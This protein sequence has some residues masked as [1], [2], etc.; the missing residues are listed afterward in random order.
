MPTRLL[1]MATV[2][3]FAPGLLR[4]EMVPGDS[5]G[6]DPTKQKLCEERS[7]ARFP[8]YTVVPFEIDKNYVARSRGVVPGFQGHSDTTFV[9]IENSILGTTMLMECSVSIGTGQYGPQAFYQEGGTPWHPIKPPQ[10]DPSISS[11]RGNEIAADRCREA[12]RIR[13]NR[14][15]FNHS[16]VLGSAV[17]VRAMRGVRY[18]V[19]GLIAGAKAERYD[20]V[21]TGTALYGSAGPDMLAI[22]FTCLFS[23]MLEVKAIQ[24]K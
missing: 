17:E 2:V 1:A 8:G 19:G 23:P 6:N 7:K 20:V 16:S 5:I 18:P 3:V 15:N 9:A 14:P 22:K 10:F 13:I 4:G 21:V 12:A 24:L 11:Q